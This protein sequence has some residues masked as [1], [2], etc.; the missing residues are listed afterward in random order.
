MNAEVKSF[1][2]EYNRGDRTGGK[3]NSEIFKQ[4]YDNKYTQR[5]TAAPTI[6]AFVYHVIQPD[7]NVIGTLREGLNAGSNNVTQERERARALEK[8]LQNLYEGTDKI[9]QTGVV[10]RTTPVNAFNLVSGV[11]MQRY[12]PGGE[13][14]SSLPPAV[15]PLNIAA[16][17][18][19]VPN[20]FTVVGQYL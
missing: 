17:Q 19:P 1:M 4:L 8:L 7:T 9:Y 6:L 2:E 13:P 12:G 20:P 5:S 15:P 10:E 3:T 16:A 18:Q 14:L 11:S